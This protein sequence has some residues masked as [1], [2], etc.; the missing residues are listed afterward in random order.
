MNQMVNDGLMPGDD[1]GALFAAS[2]VYLQK[3]LPILEEKISAFL[4]GDNPFV[5]ELLEYAAAS[6]GKRVRPRFTMLAAATAGGVDDDVV[7]I[8]AAVE[9]VHLATLLHDDVIDESQ[10][11]RG[12]P[13]TR[14]RFGNKLSILGGDYILTRV[15]QYLM[16]SR[17]SAEIMNVMITTTNR[18]VVGEFVQLW[19]QGRLDLTEEEYLNIIGLKSA[20]FIAASCELGAIAAGAEPAGREALAEFGRNAGLSFQIT[21]DRLDYDGLAGVLGKERFADVRSGKITLPVIYGLRTPFAGKIAATVEAIWNGEDAG[22]ELALL[23]EKAGAIDK[24]RAAARK[25]AD[26]GKNALL[27]VRAG[28]ARDLLECL[29]D[30]TWQRRY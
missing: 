3:Y 18:M 2:G 6:G 16:R 9:C 30:W 15:F 22:D 5:R 26:A 13:A 27:A 19:R 12:R 23:L 1:A 14:E 20:N 25:F 7:A 10:L 11:R 29:A 28:E 24:T 8:A 4:G 21:D 17:Y